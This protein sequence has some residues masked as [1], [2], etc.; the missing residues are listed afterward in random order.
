MLENWWSIFDTCFIHSNAPVFSG[1]LNTNILI[2]SSVTSRLRTT[3]IHHEWQRRF[4]QVP[5]Q[6]LLHTQLPELGLGEQPCLHGLPREY[7]KPSIQNVLTFEKAEGREDEQH[8]RLAPHWATTR[9]IVV[10]RIHDGTLQYTMMELV[11]PTEPGEKFWTLR[12]K[13]SQPPPTMPVT[14][15]MPNQS[16]LAASRFDT[17]SSKGDGY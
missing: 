14:S 1:S 5:L 11:A 16:S 13:D 3:K 2:L 7:L 9:D 10:P 8:A 15:A 6:V 12:D 4:L 17:A